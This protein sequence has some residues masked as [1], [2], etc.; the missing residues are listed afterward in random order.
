MRTGILATCVLGILIL[1]SSG[2]TTKAPKYFDLSNQLR[3]PNYAGG[4]CVYAS[5]VTV[6]RWQHQFGLADQVRS[7][8]SGACSEGSLIRACENLNIKYA[9]TV[10]GDPKFLDWCDRTNRGAVI[11][12]FDNHSVTFACYTNGLASLIDNNDPDRKILIPKEQ[13]LKDWKKYGGFALT[14]VYSPSPPK[15]RS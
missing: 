6:L 15:P 12:Y 3:Q 1:A 14:A 5:L 10:R 2:E 7:G 8:Y 4:S 13:F 9:Y 11:F